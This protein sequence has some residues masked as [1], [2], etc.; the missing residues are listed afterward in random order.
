M[1]VG[2]G[3]DYFGGMEMNSAAGT[4]KSGKGMIYTLFVVVF[5]S[6]LYIFVALQ[7]DKYRGSS[8]GEKIRGDELG[9]FVKGIGDDIERSLQISGRKAVL[10]LVNYEVGTGVNVTGANESILELMQNGT[11]DGNPQD[12][13]KNGTISEWIGRIQKIGQRRGIDINITTADMR[14]LPASAFGFFVRGNALVVAYD[15]L[16]RIRYNRTFIVSREI[17]V[18]GLEDPFVAIKSGGLQRNVIRKCNSTT[19]TGGTD[20]WI[21]GRT[22]I[23]LT[24]TDYFYVSDKGSKIL[25]VD[26]LIGRENYTGF[27]AIVS[28][29][30]DAPASPYINNA[31]QSTSISDNVLAVK[32]NRTL[33]FTNISGVAATSCYFVAPAGPSFF[34][35]LEGRN[36]THPKYDMPGVT[37]GIAA[38]IYVPPSN[39]ELDYLHSW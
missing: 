24:K 15:P 21:Q 26:T 17:P 31:M 12:L 13:M 39:Y 32:E 28:E 20:D 29:A 35:R 11:L 30:S 10:S 23:N 36:Y 19:G 25:L 34:D 14:V 2:A 6:A 5:L 18:D 7:G 1:D 8:V 37:E 9:F 33:W 22:Y 16:A 3:S 38:Y 27:A 4:G